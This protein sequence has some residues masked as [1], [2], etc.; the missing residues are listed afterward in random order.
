M[1]GNESYTEMKRWPYTDTDKKYVYQIPQLISQLLYEKVK[2]KLYENQR[3]ADNNKK[4]LS[5]LDG[6]LECSFGLKMI[7]T[8]KKRYLE[9]GEHAHECTNSKSLNREPTDIV[10]IDLVKGVVSDSVILKEQFKNYV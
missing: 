9:R 7:F 1:L 5:V 10:I 6:C 4:H 2:K 3:T 8:S